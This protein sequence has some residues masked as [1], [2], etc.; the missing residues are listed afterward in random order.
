MEGESSAI[1]G[2]RPNYR[3]TATPATASAIPPVTCPITTRL[4]ELY[5]ECVDNGVWARVLYQ[6]RGGIEKLTFLRKKTPPSSRQPGRRPASERRRERNKK[7]RE[8]WAERRQNRSRARSLATVNVGGEATVAAQA[9]SIS[10]PTSSTPIPPDPPRKRAKIVTDAVK[11]SSRS[12]DV[13][14]RRVIHQLDGGNTSSS[15]CDT[16]LYEDIPPTT[17]TAPTPAPPMTALPAPV[18]PMTAPPVPEPPMAAPPPPTAP[19]TPPPW[20]VHLP[21]YPPRVIC[22][23]C[24]QDSHEVKNRKYWNCWKESDRNK[25][26]DALDEAKMKNP[27]A[28]HFIKI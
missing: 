22:R 17:S 1:S 7:R 15:S 16:S 14:K 19:P 27:T 8:A 13:A 5:Q 3:L 23:F 10:P 9:V 20:S 25:A 26:K 6:A 18:P 12:A 28:L 11:T 4:L 24:F 21:S 2:S